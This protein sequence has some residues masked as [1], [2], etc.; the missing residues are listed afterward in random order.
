MALTTLLTINDFE[1]PFMIV[2][3][4]E[5]N[6]GYEEYFDDILAKSQKDFLLNILGYRMYDTMVSDYP[7][8]GFYDYLVSGKDYTESG[9]D[10]NFEGILPAL[11]RYTY[12]KWQVFNEDQLQSSGSIRQT[13]EESEKVIPVNKMVLAYNEMVDLLNGSDSYAPTVYHY[14]DTQYTGDDWIYKGFEKIN[15]FNL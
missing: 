7:D 2:E 11:M 12:F 6:D 1:N 9:I 10:Y 15:S 8:G 4:L 3:K 14:I 13:F 5:N